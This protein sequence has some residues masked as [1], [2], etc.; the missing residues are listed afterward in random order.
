MGEP[1]DQ[2]LTGMFHAA[3]SGATPP[4]GFDVASVVRASRRATARRRSAVAGGA[5]AVLL[6]AGAVTAAVTVTGSGDGATTSAAAAPEAATGGARGD[7]ALAPPAAAPSGAGSDAAAGCA[8]LQDP[9]LRALLDD[10]LPQV[11]GAAE[12]PTAMVCKQGGGREVHLQVVDGAS[13]GLLAV[14]FTPPGEPVDDGLPTGLARAGAPT[15]SGGYVT[16]TS[17]PDAGSGGIPFEDRLA[18][19]AAGLA[20]RL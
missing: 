12:A 4:P 5:A 3:G 2:E 10:V 16:V 18:A 17:R 19:T 20:S 6:V 13:N 8:N 15:A 7:A 14:V 1:T 9:G 11:R